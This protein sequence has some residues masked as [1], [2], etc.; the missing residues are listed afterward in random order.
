MSGELVEWTKVT[1]LVPASK[2]DAVNEL[3]A[4][5][6]AT[7]AEQEPEQI[8][9]LEAMAMW[10]DEPTAAVALGWLLYAYAHRMGFQ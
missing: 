8:A 1:I 9:Q 7:L 6:W 5:L 10:A 3:A 4:S 2:L